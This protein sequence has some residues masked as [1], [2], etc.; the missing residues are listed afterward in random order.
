M[1]IE[2]TFES[3]VKKLRKFATTVATSWCP[4]TALPT[5]RTSW[6]MT[7]AAISAAT[8]RRTMLHGRVPRGA[9]CM[10]TT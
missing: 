2:M 1:T 5:D 4:S 7:A 10:G 3:M 9:L 8:S 6:A